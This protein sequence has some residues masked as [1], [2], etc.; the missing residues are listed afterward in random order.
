MS[1]TDDACVGRRSCLPPENNGAQES[2]I[3]P[4]RTEPTSIDVA[5][6]A[7]NFMLFYNLQYELLE[8]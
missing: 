4:R 3:Y 8:S 7:G 5:S 2:P 6:A 1:L